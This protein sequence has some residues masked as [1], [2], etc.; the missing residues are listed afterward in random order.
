MNLDIPCGFREPTTGSL[1]ELR[2]FRI[3]TEVF[4]QHR[5]APEPK[6]LYRAMDANRNTYY[7]WM[8]KWVAEGVWP[9]VGASAG[10]SADLSALAPAEDAQQAAIAARAAARYEAPPEAPAP[11]P[12]LAATKEF[13]ART[14]DDA[15]LSD[16][17]RT[18][19]ALG[20][21]RAPVADAEASSTIPDDEYQAMLRD[22]VALEFGDAIAAALAVGGASSAGSAPA[23][24]G[25]AE[26][27][28]EGPGEVA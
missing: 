16:D 7:T 14:R 2:A 13:L 12:G 25:I 8:R 18:K 23:P 19:A 17:I 11:D 5:G 22:A 6:H 27:K 10:A 20:L 3:A 28:A 24:L 26:A 1:H 4:K 21:L 15:S 9:P